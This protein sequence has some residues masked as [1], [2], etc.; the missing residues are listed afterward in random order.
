MWEMKHKPLPTQT[1]PPKLALL[2]ATWDKTLADLLLASADMDDPDDPN[3]IW[4]QRVM[5]SIAATFA[6]CA[7]SVRL[8]FDLP[9]RFGDLDATKMA[10]AD[11]PTDSRNAERIQDL[12]AHFMADFQDDA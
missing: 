2:V 11:E 8:A 6:V 7:D 3:A 9:R 12:I 10:L 5:L 1:L 4:G